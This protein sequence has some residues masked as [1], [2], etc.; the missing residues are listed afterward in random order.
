MTTYFVTHVIL[1]DS[2]VAFSLRTFVFY[3]TRATTAN[4]LVVNSKDSNERLK[5][6][7]RHAEKSKNCVVIAEWKKVLRRCRLLLFMPYM[8]L[9]CWQGYLSLSVHFF[10]FSVDKNENTV[11]F[12]MNEGKKLALLLLH[13]S[14]YYK[15]GEWFERILSTV[16]RTMIEKWWH[17]LTSE[18]GSV[19]SRIFGVIMPVYCCLL[20]PFIL[21]RS[22]V[23]LQDRKE[24]GLC[25]PV[26]DVSERWGAFNQ[27][28]ERNVILYVWN[29]F[30]SLH[31]VGYLTN[32]KKRHVHSFFIFFPVPQNI[33]AEWRLINIDVRFTFSSKQILLHP[34]MHLI[35]RT[36]NSN[37]EKE[38]DCFNDSA[39]EDAQQG[40]FAIHTCSSRCSSSST[41]TSVQTQFGSHSL[42]SQ[43]LPCL[44]QS[45]PL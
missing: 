8:C 14:R 35:M 21:V 45:V 13:V 22:V 31:S 24:G 39:D 6:K 5:K 7:E 2:T 15:L 18:W 3:N 44:L 37:F 19:R 25:I 27:Q 28:M 36:K 16:N 11:G 40:S 23:L 34:A 33:S 29:Q 32:K 38:I 1:F 30:I 10:S 12:S 20:L 4:W 42:V 43:V 9:S 26:R 41:R 17:R